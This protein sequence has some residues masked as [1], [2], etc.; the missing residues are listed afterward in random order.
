MS[1]IH[2]LANG[3]CAQLNPTQGGF[4]HGFG[5]FETLQLRAGKLAFWEAHWAR[6]SASADALGFSFTFTQVEALAAVSEYCLGNGVQAGVVKLSLL[7][8]GTTSDLYVYGRPA[9]TAPSSVQ[10]VVDRRYPVFPDSLL[11][12][13]KTHNYMESIWLLQ[14]AREGGSYDA[15][16][17]NT[18]GYLAETC[19]A[20]LF[21]LK[22]GV[23]C[24]P[25]LDCGI[26]PGVVRAAILQL[27][28]DTG[29]AVECGQYTVEA[30]LAADA[31]FTSNSTNLISPVAA[32]QV[33]DVT[34][35]FESLG[36][37][38]IAA[39]KKALAEVE[40]KSAILVIGH[41]AA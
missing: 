24:T 18:G 8:A 36:H 33:G 3:A 39:L 32:I 9:T 20:N 4:A 14:S 11:A 37:P 28:A 26:L 23:L 38:A 6:L 30:L 2:V 10:L 22:D 40:A 31:V 25:G 19:I 12:G 5:L 21:F 7:Q 34:H 41:G 13:H 1:L 17:L 35:R 15:L 27:C 16:R 29:W